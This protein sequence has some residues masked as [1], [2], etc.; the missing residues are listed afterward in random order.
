MA[1]F[2][3]NVTGTIA[4]DAVTNAKAA[5]MAAATLKGRAVGGG[6]GD[7]QDLSPDEVLDILDTATDAY[8]RLTQSATNIAS[9]VAAEASAR[10]S[11][12]TSV[13]SSA[14]TYAQ[15]V[16]DAKVE[17]AIV[18]GVTTKAPSQNAVFDAL[19]LK[20]DLAS[21]A[22]TGT[23][24]APTPTAGD[25]ST[26]LATT[27]FVDAIAQLA[28]LPTSATGAALM[29]D[30]N[31][32]LNSP[33]SPSSA[34][35]TLDTSSA[36]ENAQVIAYFNH[37]SEPS[38]PAGITAVGHWNNS[39]LNVVYFVYKGT[40]N[41][42][43][44]IVSD[45]TVAWTNPTTVTKQSSDVVNSTTTPAT[46]TG[47][48]ITGVANHTYAVHGWVRV[49]GN[50]GVGANLGFGGALTSVNANYFGASTNVTTFVTGPGNTVGTVATPDFGEFTTAGN[51]F[52]EIYAT[53]VVDG[54]GGA[55]NLIGASETGGTA[56]TFR[57][58]NS[59]LYWTDLG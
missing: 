15:G 27:A 35:V 20:A 40:S 58:Q 47:H 44:T 53:L 55:I 24:T 5:N 30:T 54:T 34:T 56:V 1:D 43:A 6:T 13:L 22:F 10:A 49:N 23:P 52:V 48:T 51:A 36:V 7:P 9:A 17:D 59:I 29:F 2:N 41:I 16:A 12:D 46:I 33:S 42:S 32:V 19:A 28:P 45:A 26:K 31:Y 57:S 39:A 21:P 4:D 8:I 25:S 50:T 3:I 14:Q 37:S 11:A 38:W 18:N